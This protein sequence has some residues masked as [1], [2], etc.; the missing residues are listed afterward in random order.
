MKKKGLGSVGNMLLGAA[1]LSTGFYLSWVFNTSTGNDTNLVKPKVNDNKTEL[2]LSVLQDKK[3]LPAGKINDLFL[4]IHAHD[5]EKFQATINSETSETWKNNYIGKEILVNTVAWDEPGMF[6]LFLPYADGQAKGEVLSRAGELGKIYYV[7]VLKEDKDVSLKSK[8]YALS[9]AAG[10]GFLEIVNL[11]KNDVPEK[12]R[13]SAAY[14]AGRKGEVESFKALLD[15]GISLEAKEK[16]IRTTVSS[17]YFSSIEGKR[18]E[19]IE[20]LV[21][22]GMPKRALVGAYERTDKNIFPEVYKFIGIKLDEMDKSGVSAYPMLPSLSKE[23]L[24]E[25]LKS[26]IRHYRPEE[27][28]LLREELGEMG[29]T[30]EDRRHP[31]IQAIME[32]HLDMF[33]VLL[34]E[35]LSED[36][37]YEALITATSGPQ[38]SKAVKSI[39]AEGVNE[40]A[41]AWGVASAVQS[42]MNHSGE[43]YDSARKSLD[44]TID[45]IWN[46]IGSEETKR[47]AVV[48]LIQK[49]PYAS[50]L[51]EQFILK[52]EIKRLSQKLASPSPAEGIKFSPK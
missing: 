25:Q 28:K 32:G 21:N 43:K 33:F 36:A 51:E 7:N 37:K 26:S 10:N 4:A 22:S 45:M 39:L 29:W 2:Q 19:I 20:A 17:T 47:M 27:F 24:I 23:G 5:V 13:D 38:R 12:E 41:K 35:G 48:E 18:I 1:L 52:N 3:A 34:E 50:R 14:S 46:A 6:D 8:G 40:Q 16:I 11:L 44:K 49:M 9:N 15:V 30:D 31:A 42:K